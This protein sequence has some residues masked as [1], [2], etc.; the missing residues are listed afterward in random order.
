MIEQNQPTPQEHQVKKDTPLNTSEPHGNLPTKEDSNNLEEITHVLSELSSEINMLNV[1]RG[2]LSGKVGAETGNNNIEKLGS[3]LMASN[4]GIE[5]LQDAFESKLM[6]DS[7]KEKII[8]KLHT[9]LEAYKND[10]RKSILKPVLNDI[11]LV[12]DNLEKLTRD[13]EPSREKGTLD[14]ENCSAR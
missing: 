5:K 4:K 9:E 13:L 1:I 14:S 7:H 6:Y 2:V 10:I 11:I 8:D 3:F 12:V